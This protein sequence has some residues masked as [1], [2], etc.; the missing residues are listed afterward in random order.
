MAVPQGSAPPRA[1]AGS[2]APSSTAG[3][4]ALSSTPAAHSGVIR[5]RSRHTGHFTVLANRLAQR[6]GSAVTVGVAAYVLSL[7]D[8]API[9]IKALCAH[10]DEGEVL[11]GRALRELEADG[12]IERRVER[13]PGGRI[14]TRTFVYDDPF[15]EHRV[16]TAEHGTA[17]PTPRSAAPPVVRPAPG[18]VNTPAPPALPPLS[19]DD[20][21]PVP[22]PP[23]RSP[24][25]GPEGVP[26]PAGGVTDPRPVAVLRSLRTR[27]ARLALTEQEIRQLAPGVGRWLALGAGSTDIAEA[28]S[29]GLPA[30]FDR[31]PARL[32]AYR[33]SAWEPPVRRPVPQAPSTPPLQNCDDCDRAFRSPRTGRCR[34]CGSR[35]GAAESTHRAA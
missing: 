31:R 34:D 6:A 35:A 12:W 23:G 7:P 29:T 24:R 27:D 14:R 26:P 25:T 10:F 9:S 28:L 11:I 16:D 4:P 19:A 33:L 22:E 13:A 20:R 30:H 1:R 18:P 8:G 17:A 32:L 5:I 15:A 21:A 3:S 2:P